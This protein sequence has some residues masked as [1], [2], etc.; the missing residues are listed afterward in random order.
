LGKLDDQVRIV[1]PVDGVTMALGARIDPKKSPATERFSIIF[2]GDCERAKGSG[3]DCPPFAVLNR[4]RD[5]AG[6][7]GARLPGPD[8]MTHQIDQPSSLKQR[9]EPVRR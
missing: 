2:C 9:D 6:R 8:G 4:Q 5:K 1:D 3:D 7:Q